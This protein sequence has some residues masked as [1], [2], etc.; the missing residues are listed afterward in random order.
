LRG[1][2]KKE[3]SP[4]ARCLKAAAVARHREAKGK[5]DRG[6]EDVDFDRKLLPAGID[7]RGLGR[8]QQVED[9]DDQDEAGVLE[10]SNERIDQRRDDV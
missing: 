7:D 1:E 9:T 6:D 10:E 8:R 5:I 3:S 2:A 4:P